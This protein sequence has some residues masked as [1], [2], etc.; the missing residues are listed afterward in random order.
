MALNGLSRWKQRPRVPKPLAVDDQRL[1]RPLMKAQDLFIFFDFDGTLV[2]L[3]PTP[4]QV[5]LSEMRKRYLKELVSLRRGGVGIV[6]GRSIDDLRRLIGIDELFYVGCHGLEWAA[7]D[8]ERSLTHLD[9]EITDA[10]RTL[11][12]ELRG[13][14]A[15]FNGILLEDK[16]M[17]LAL[18]YRRANERA[19]L[20][21][22]RE[23]VR[24]VY[25]YQRQGIALELLAGKA[26]IEAKAPGATK[27]DVV[28]QII[29]HYFPGAYPIYFGDDVTDESAF[30][31]VRRRGLAL[32][33][34]DTPRATAAQHFVKTPNEVY[35]FLRCLRHMCQGAGSDS[36]RKFAH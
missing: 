18:H 9:D 33:V 16:G 5:K 27:G 28:K 11:C 24:A 23:F 17:S 13:S 21:A 35:L 29:S 20:A 2:E 36:L 26:V 22:R 30:Q 1:W 25:W 4:S 7:P 3:A 19:A 34:A 31:V 15:R 14:L 8:G 10:L 12:D 32:L 6:S